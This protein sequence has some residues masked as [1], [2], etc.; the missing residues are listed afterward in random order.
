[1]NNETGSVL[2]DFDRYMYRR[3]GAK[4]RGRGKTAAQVMA[5][6]QRISE[7]CEGKYRRKFV[8]WNDQVFS[9]GMVYHFEREAMVMPESTDTP[10]GLPG[11][12]LLV[13]K[14]FMVDDPIMGEFPYLY[15]AILENYQWD[16]YDTP[17]DIRH[18]FPLCLPGYWPGLE[19][20][21]KYDGVVDVNS[22]RVSE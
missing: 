19:D 3:I 21:L 7:W 22:L 6:A 14:C 17:V 9:E 18:V 1:M 15:A 5:M 8:E 12:T 2:S 13:W 16:E 4:F 11:D 10:Y 20:V